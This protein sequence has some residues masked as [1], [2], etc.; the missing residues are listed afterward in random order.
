MNFEEK[1]M[2]RL[3]ALKEIAELLNE[4]TVNVLYNLFTMYVTMFN[5]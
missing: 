5:T 4:A 1:E 2:H 3:E